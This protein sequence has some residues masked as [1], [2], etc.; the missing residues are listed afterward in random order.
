[1]VFLLIRVLPFVL[2][3]F[4]L[5]IM[6]LLFYFSGWW[7]LI[8]F[9][10]LI[11]DI[12]YFFLFYI[13]VKIKEI[14]FVSVHSIL[15]L[16]TGFIFSFLLSNNVVINLYIIFWSF[17]YFI[18]LESVFHYFYLTR[19]FF[20]IDFKNIITYINLLIFFLVVASLINGYI[21][22]NLSWWWVCIIYLV[23]SF[24]LI[25]VYFLIHSIDRKLRNLYTAIITVILLELMIVILFLPVSFYVSAITLSVVY[26]LLS[27]LTL[28]QL[29]HQ[30]TRSL[31]SQYIIFAI[32]I[33]VLVFATAA[34]I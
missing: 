30:L 9:S 14:L 25:W 2:P 31:V 6:K 3:L 29:Q 15:F 4:Y 23:I 13:R 18:Y 34:W 19:K 22:L 7:Y 11:L 26:Y 17:I 8:I 1:M 32:I 10:I 16:I 33:L 28:F 24:F 12:L 20:I 21:F 5:A 27:S